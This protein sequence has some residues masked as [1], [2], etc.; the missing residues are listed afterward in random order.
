MILIDTGPLVAVI[1]RGDQD[2][3][4]CSAFLLQHGK[5]FITTW[6]V[7]TEAHYFLGNLAGWPGQAAL[8]KI[9]ERGVVDVAD[10]TSTGAPV[11]HALMEKY[12]D[13]PMDLADASLVA[14]AEARDL[15][16]VFTLDAD[17]EVYRKHRRQTFHLRP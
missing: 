8:W 13:V 6:S 15:R 9:V 5:G 14:L 4:K 16:V 17:F 12:R 10:S 11:L 7:M 1:N 3:A 2:H